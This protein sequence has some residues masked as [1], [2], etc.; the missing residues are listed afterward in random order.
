L[1]AHREQIVLTLTSQ[2][3]TSNPNQ[4]YSLSRLTPTISVISHKSNAITPNRHSYADLAW[5][6]NKAL[7]TANESFLV[8][9]LRFNK[10][11]ESEKSKKNKQVN[12]YYTN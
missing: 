6:C 10:E 1:T 2:C 9:G 3:F 12:C 4:T 8:G 5:T 7:R 11:I